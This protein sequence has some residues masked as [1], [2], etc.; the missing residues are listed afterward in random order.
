MFKAIKQPDIG[1]SCFSIQV[2]ESLISDKVKPLSD[3][4]EACLVNNV[5][6]EDAEITKY[7]CWIDSFEPNHRRYFK[8]LGQAPPKVK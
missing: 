6:D 8:D 5:L 2:V 4:L 1:E 3:L 7:T